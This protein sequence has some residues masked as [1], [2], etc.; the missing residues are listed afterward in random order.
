MGMYTQLMFNAELRKDTPDQVISILE[1]MTGDASYG[2]APETPEH[3]LF[4]TERWTFMLV[5]SSYYFEP[6]ASKTSFR[7]DDITK[8]W[9]L[10]VLCDLKNYSGEI[11]AFLDWIMPYLDDSNRQVLGWTWYEEDDEP[12]LIRKGDR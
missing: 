9:H 2:I 1:F 6:N 8:S 5:S 4:D 12:T 3:A 7:K 11:E 10:S